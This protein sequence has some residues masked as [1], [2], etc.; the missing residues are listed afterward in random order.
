MKGRFIVAA[1]ND[2]NPGTNFIDNAR[3]QRHEVYW[4][5]PTS[6]HA[7]SYDN[8][9]DLGNS[10]WL[11]TTDKAARELASQL[12]AMHPNVYFVFGPLQGAFMSV[13]NK[14]TEMS[15]SSKGVLPV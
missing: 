8:Y 10:P 5:V 4:R 12:A 14:P 15:I 7:G 13:P 2:G 11:V 3:V 9:L 1:T 6:T